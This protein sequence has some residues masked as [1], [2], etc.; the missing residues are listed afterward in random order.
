MLDLDACWRVVE[1]RD[2]S[3][4]G[5][6]YYGVRT[7][8]VYCRPGC[9]SRRPLRTNTVFFETTAAAETG[10]FRPCKRCRPADDSAASRHLAAIEKACALLRN[11]ETM[12]SL[13]ELADAAAISRFHFHRVFKQI[14]GTTPRDYARTHRLGQFGRRLEAG[15]P[16]TEAIYASGF[17]SSSRAY[18]AAPAGLGMTPGARRRGGSGETIRFVTVSTPLG[19]ALVAATARGICMT[20]L[21]DDRDQLAS[22]LR[23]RFPAAE[24]VAEDGGLRQWADRIV[25][26]ITAPE[27][28]LDL[29]LDIRGTAFQARVWRAL[30]K[31]PLGTTMSYAEVATALGQPKAVRAVAQACAANKLALIV[32]CHRVIR[33]D[34]DLGGYR[35]GVE[36]KQA[37]LARERASAAHDEAAA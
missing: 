21:G 24:V 6:F 15:Q 16:V 1:N 18:E 28:N 9:A 7:T 10:G 19:W 12:P 26:F 11:S 31:I 13:A 5:N 35:W 30:Q 22:A 32:P 2:A 29:P 20:A 37:L 3:A 4:D 27:R 36:R 34:G 23:Q 8:G 17:G 25:R 33:S 14:T